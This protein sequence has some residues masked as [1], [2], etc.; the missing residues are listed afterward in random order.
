M[1]EVQQRLDEETREK[2]AAEREP[3]IWNEVV[4]D[5][6]EKWL[7]HI[8][9]TGDSEFLYDAAEG[10]YLF[11][12]DY[13]SEGEG[14]LMAS[15]DEEE[16]IGREREQNMNEENGSSVISDEGIY[17]GLFTHFISYGSPRKFVR[18]I[19]LLSQSL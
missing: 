4:V 2:E 3:N 14:D 13:E 19:A 1:R 12:E 18:R 7:P 17:I 8:S 5:I 10:R 11:Q 6:W 16:D 9:Y 15:G